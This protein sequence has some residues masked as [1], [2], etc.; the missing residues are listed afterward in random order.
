[1]LQPLPRVYS[2]MM[3]LCSFENCSK[4]HEWMF[5]FD[6]SVENIPFH[7][8]DKRLKRSMRNKFDL[9]WTRITVFG[10]RMIGLMGLI[11][12]IV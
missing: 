3:D 6:H 8:M 10:C 9:V 7:E 1:M 11:G 2:S 12:D 5:G 4:D